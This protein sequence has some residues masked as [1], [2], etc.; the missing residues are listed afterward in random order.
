M[1]YKEILFIFNLL[2]KDLALIVAAREFL[3]PKSTWWKLKQQKN[4]NK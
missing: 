2:S 4:I 1:N 3:Q